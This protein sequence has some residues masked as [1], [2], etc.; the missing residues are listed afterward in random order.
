LSGLILLAAGD[1]L[2]TNLWYGLFVLA[3]LVCASGDMTQMHLSEARE[4]AGV[5]ATGSRGL[6][7]GV[8]VPSALAVVAVGFLC[9]SVLPQRQGMNL[10]MMPTSLFQ[11]V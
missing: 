2:S 6:A 8:V 4:Q 7:R 1:V 5:P 9:F 11:N 10:T 3:F